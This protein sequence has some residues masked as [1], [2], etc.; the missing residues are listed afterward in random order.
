MFT[1]NCIIHLVKQGL[2]TN[3]DL[4]DVEPFTEMRKHWKSR[5]VF[6]Y[7]NFNTQ[8]KGAKKKEFDAQNM[9]E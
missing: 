7:I 2:L 5:K 9:K 3:H 4:L 8:S 1:F 6:I